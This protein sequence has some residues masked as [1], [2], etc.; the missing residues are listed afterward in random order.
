MGDPALDLT[1]DDDAFIAREVAKA[2]RGF[3][4]RGVVALWLFEAPAERSLLVIT[5][6]EDAARDEAVRRQLELVGA[7]RVAFLP[8]DF[9]VTVAGGVQLVPDPAPD[10]SPESA[11]RRTERLRADLA[12]IGVSLDDP[13]VPVGD[14]EWQETLRD[15]GL[16]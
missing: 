9:P 1:P 14:D 5:R 4:A 2:V 15:L 6:G 16:P 7:R 3:G 13:I 11:R 12:G 10:N 8:D